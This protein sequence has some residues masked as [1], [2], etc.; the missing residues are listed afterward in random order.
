MPL[1]LQGPNGQTATCQSAEFVE[2][3]QE[4]R[5]SSTKAV[6]NGSPGLIQ[7]AGTSYY[8]VIC[9]PSELMQFS[10]LRR[11]LLVQYTKYTSIHI[12]TARKLTTK[13]LRDFFVTV[14]PF[15]ASFRLVFPSSTVVL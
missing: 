11:I 7:Q 15:I 5:I 12:P 4:C 2:S 14:L 13:L 6:A 1:M 9:L 10:I 3:T 8:E